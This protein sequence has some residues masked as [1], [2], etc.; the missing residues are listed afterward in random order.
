M[1]FKL[2]IPFTLAAGIV[3]LATPVFD[4]PNVIPRAEIPVGITVHEYNATAAVLGAAVALKS[5]GLLEERSDCHGSG[6]C[7]SFVHGDKCLNAALVSYRE[8]I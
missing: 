3:V 2:F 7:K 6:V 5:R 1:L 4:F 8:E